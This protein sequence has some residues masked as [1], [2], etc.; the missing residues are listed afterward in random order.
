MLVFD[1]LRCSE[2]GNSCDLCNIW[3]QE[4]LKP[5]VFFAVPV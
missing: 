2:T 3:V 1:P 4:F 5:G